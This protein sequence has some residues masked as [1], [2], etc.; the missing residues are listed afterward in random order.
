M[1]DSE[2]RTVE[3]EKG[4]PSLADLPDV[5]LRLRCELTTWIPLVQ[6]SLPAPHSVT[7]RVRSSVLRIE[8]VAA[9]P[10]SAPPPSA[11]PIVM[12][13]F[14]GSHARDR[15]PR[16]VMCVFPTEQTARRPEGVARS[17][18]DAYA[19]PF[20]VGKLHDEATKTI[21][22][23]RSALPTS[24]VARADASLAWATS[25]V[26]T[27]WPARKSDVSGKPR[28]G[29]APPP[30]SDARS[31]DAAAE[32]DPAAWDMDPTTVDAACGGP[33]PSLT[34]VPA[35]PPAA[36]RAGGAW[37]GISR[38]AI[39]A[40]PWPGLERPGDAPQTVADHAVDFP[41]AVAQLAGLVHVAAAVLPAAAGPARVVKTALQGFSRYLG[42]AA[43]SAAVCGAP[44]AVEV[45]VATGISAKVAVEAVSLT[46]LPWEAV[47]VPPGIRIE[48]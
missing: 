35:G 2:S 17:L 39:S 21:A 45:P 1:D 32:A 26:A 33:S 13:V 7:L 4:L 24:V 19:G 9:G 6:G 38:W 34:K 10:E 41:L 8:V 44:V 36:G 22:N 18:Y 43:L 31:A 40:G 15:A 25:K 30:P 11:A 12:L 48:A 46:P 28:D 47:E 23:V 37:G 5:E 20:S 42:V 14:N 16:G 29:G 27:L 3:A